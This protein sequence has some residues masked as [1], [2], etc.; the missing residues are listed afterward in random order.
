MTPLKFPE[1]FF[2]YI[3][4]NMIVGYTKLYSNREKASI[5]FEITNEKNRLF[6]SMLLHSECLMLPDR[7][8]YWEKAPR[9]FS[10]TRSDSMPIYTFESILI[11]IFIFVTAKTQDNN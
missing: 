8:T 6:L 1:F 9:Y 4:V 7:K 3:L 2:D 5:S 11:G 10:V